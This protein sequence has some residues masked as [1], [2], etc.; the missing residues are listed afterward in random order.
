MIFGFHNLRCSWV[1]F[2]GAV[3][4]EVLLHEASKRDSHRLDEGLN[5]E[6]TAVKASCYPAEHTDIKPPPEL[7]TESRGIKGL[8]K[9]LCECDKYETGTERMWTETEWGKINERVG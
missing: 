8:W 6:W 4:A 5:S 7:V 1:I 2:L 9:S 3:T